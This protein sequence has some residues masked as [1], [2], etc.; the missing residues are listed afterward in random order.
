MSKPTLE[1]L[2]TASFSFPF[3]VISIIFLFVS[4]II[5]PTQGAKLPFNP[6]KIEFGMCFF[7]KSFWCLTS[8]RIISGFKRKFLNSL[9]SKALSPCRMTSSKGISVDRVQPPW[10]VYLH[11]VLYQ[12]L[13]LFAFILVF[14]IKSKTN[15]DWKNRRFST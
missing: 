10:A 9:S 5:L 13:F 11:G 2:V 3:G 6:I 15:F 12:N 1:S 14:S 4:P 7:I 8:R